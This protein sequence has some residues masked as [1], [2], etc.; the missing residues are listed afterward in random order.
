[1]K[2]TKDEGLVADVHSLSAGLK[3][4]TTSY[5]NAALSCVQATRGR[6]ARLQAWLEP[7]AAPCSIGA[8]QRAAAAGVTCPRL[9]APAPA[10]S[11]GWRAAG[12][13]TR[14]SKPAGRAAQRPRHL[15]DL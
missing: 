9:P 5:V 2:R 8:L 10:A 12:T 7:P 11:A 3:A 1:M 14:R 6:A 15:P 13:A 4:Y